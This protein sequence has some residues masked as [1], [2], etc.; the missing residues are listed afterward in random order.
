M[1]FYKT[2]KEI[3]IIRE[4]AQ[5]LSKTLGLIGKEIKPG[6]TTLEL[7]QLA[8]TYI[9]DSGA[10]PSFKGY[11]PSFSGNKAFPAALC[12][13]VNDEVV[14]GIPGKYALQEGDIVSIDLGVFYKGFHSDA[15]YTFPVGEIS[16]EAFNLLKVTKE[17]LY[18]GIEQAIV[19]KRV[20]DI[21]AAIEQHVVAHGYSPV[22]ALAGHGVG[23]QLHEDPDVFNYGRK[24][25]GV[26]LNKGMVIA[27]EPMIN[28]GKFAVIFSKGD[29]WTVTTRDGKLSAH[30]EHTVAIGEKTAEILTTYRYIE[31][32][33]QF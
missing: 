8:D 27:I 9:Q 24:G 11:K 1:I 13:S 25:T 22:R 32:G 23:V 2:D 26:R 18:L 20:G 30:F 14:H 3:S 6:I 17:S 15:A 21:G 31:E 19:G 5:I 10:N 4:S 12:S 7:A 33:L 28:Q 29:G 16:D